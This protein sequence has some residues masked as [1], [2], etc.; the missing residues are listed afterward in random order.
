MFTDGRTR[1]MPESGLKV[2]TICLSGGC[3]DVCICLLR[4][5][6]PAETGLEQKILRGPALRNQQKPDSCL[7]K[8]QCLEPLNLQLLLRQ[9][10]RG[11]RR[12][13]RGWFLSTNANACVASGPLQLL[14][15]RYD[16]RA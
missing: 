5:T 15:C 13:G 9:L 14:A 12:R 4:L 10:F 8:S 7:I 6:A 1:V 11:V 16:L 3:T 2:R